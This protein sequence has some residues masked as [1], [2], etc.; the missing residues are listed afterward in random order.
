[1]LLLNNKT[2]I[3]DYDFDY[4][5][6]VEV[7]SSWDNL[8]DTA[9]FTLPKKIT[10]RNRFNFITDRITGRA[11]NPDGTPVVGKNMP[12]FLQGDRATLSGGYGEDVPQIFS[13]FIRSVAP[14]H[15]IKITFEDSMYLLKQK[16][17]EDFSEENISLK[18]VVEKI[19]QG[20]DIELNVA[21]GVEFEVLR[22][23]PMTA[24]EILNHIKKSYGLVSWF[25]GNVLNVGLAYLSDQPEGVLIH[26]FFGSG[27][28]CNIIDTT[29]LEYKTEDQ[30]RIKLKV[31][32]IFKDDTKKEVTVGDLL[33]GELRTKFVY[34]VSESGLLKV[35]NE[36][37]NKMVFEGYNGSFETFL[38]PLV[39][40][41]DAVKLTD[42]EFPDRKGV[43]L[44]KEVVYNYGINGGR[45]KI[46][47]DRKIS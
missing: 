27:Q 26:E 16:L 12:V 24:A 46:S 13:G 44:V 31:V 17:I 10:Y 2:K 39:R 18:E 25:K 36:E 32:S 40:H 43:Y 11:F 47:L 6:T 23:P 34:G 3:E 21:D 35:A 38:L 1:M 14:N 8:T 15:P 4:L 33:N 5:E 29:N 41:G 22:Y 7:I 45:Q 19:T 37:L 20:V 42:D 28:R 30:V 9:T